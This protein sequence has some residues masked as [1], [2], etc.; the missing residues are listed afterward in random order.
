MKAILA[1]LCVALIAVGGGAIHLWR[2]LDAA[3]QEIADLNSHIRTTTDSAHEADNIAPSPSLPLAEPTAAAPT[4]APAPD[5][6]RERKIS[7]EANRLR[8]MLRLPSGPESKAQAKSRATS[9]DMP[10]QYPDVGQALG[11]SR[12]EVDQLFDLLY[13]QSQ[14]RVSSDDPVAAARMTQTAKDELVSLLGS[15]YPK[16][17][18]YNSELPMRRHVKDLTVVLDAAGTPLSDAQKKP[19][20]QALAAAETRNR[21]LY[22]AAHP[23]PSNGTSMAGFYRYTPE[24][25]ANLLNA[26]SA[27]LTPQQ[28]EA[29]RQL[30]E[31]ASNREAV[32]QGWVK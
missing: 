16:W 3:R 5:A 26:A 22:E 12:D 27:Y 13:E 24:A 11:L 6:E 15:K 21:E 18:E 20:L 2:Q 8:A 19:L 9:G 29:Y 30:L 17:E 4:V 7:E 28:M 32:M 14:R 31:R 25:T 1:I 23:T 10:S